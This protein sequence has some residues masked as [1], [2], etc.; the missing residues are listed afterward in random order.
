MTARIDVWQRWCQ[1][2]L[3][4][5]YG[6][7]GIL[8]IVLP[9]PFL[10][11]TPAWVPEPE[12]VIFLTG[13]CEIAGAVGLLVPRLRKAAGIGLAFYAICVFPA[14]IKHAIDSLGAVTVS[15]WQWSYHLIRLPLQPCLVWLALFAG[16]IVV[17]PFRRGEK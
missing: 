17:W 16:N 4:S 1:W 10:G 13:L 6:L 3:S 15:P 12:A 2:G 8:H 11:I 14:N 9:K 7:A 5:L